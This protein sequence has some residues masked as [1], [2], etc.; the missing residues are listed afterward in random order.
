MNRTVGDVIELT[1]YILGFSD[2]KYRIIKMNEAQNDFI[3]LV[4]REY[5]EAI[6]EDTLGSVEPTINILKSQSTKVML[7]DASVY[8]IRS[9]ERGYVL[10]SK[11]S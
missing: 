5:N 7:S 11:S 1:D 6:Y 2:K 9:D 8:I 4:A 10:Q 3:E